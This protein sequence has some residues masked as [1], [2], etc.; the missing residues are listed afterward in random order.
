MSENE[1]QD[2]ET[3]APAAPM[4]KKSDDFHGLFE[5]SQE[6]GKEIELATIFNDPDECDQ[7]IERIVQVAWGRE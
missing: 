3:D 6:F 4:E 2:G 1:V 5:P 7:G